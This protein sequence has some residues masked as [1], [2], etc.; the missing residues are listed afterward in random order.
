MPSICQNIKTE[1]EHLQD[2]K[3]RFSL[4]FALAQKS[5]NLKAVK[6]LKYE[7]EAAYAA[8]EAKLYVSV[9]EAR[10]ILGKENVFGSKEVEKTWGVR[11]AE[12]PYIPFSAEELERAKELGQMLVLR[13]N[14]TAEG[15]PMSMEAMNAIL[16]GTE[17]NP[18]KWQKAGKGGLLDSVDDW[19]RW[20]GEDFFTKETPRSGWALVSKDVLPV[21]INKD[22]LEQT[23]IIISA[24]RKNAFKEIDLPQEYAEAIAEFESKKAELASLI[25]ENW[26]EMKRQLS[27]LKITQ[28]TR[29]TIPEIVYDV[30]IYYDRSNERL[31]S[32]DY[33]LSATLSIIGHFDASGVDHM[34]HPDNRYGGLGV[35]L[36]SRL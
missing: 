36:S 27:A 16:V 23:E 34:W 20:I 1:Y 22:E 2:L 32:D 28:L 8:L 4:E 33:T 3:E 11:L 30:A 17:K 7:W 10:E 19:E 29:Q 31:L 25:D 35:S 6:K 24:L 13:V 15:K 12:V 5:G 26:N 14:K 18:G 9:E 21:S